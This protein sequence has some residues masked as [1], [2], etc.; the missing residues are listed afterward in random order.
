MH[1]LLFEIAQ[2]SS[3]PELVKGSHDYRDLQRL[4]R[5]HLMRAS[6]P[7]RQLSLHTGRSL[8]GL[9]NSIRHS[10][11]SDKKKP[12][13]HREKYERKKE[14][15]VLGQQAKPQREIPVENR[16]LI[17][18]NVTYLGKRGRS[19]C[20]N[21]HLATCVGCRGFIGPVPL[22]LWIRAV[23]V[24]YQAHDPVNSMVVTEE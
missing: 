9:G 11:L 10:Y 3:V 7:H 13:R 8:N 12:E 1:L 16:S 4:I 22:P 19:L 15:R 14:G 21:W 23:E 6:G 2:I 20:R 17:F 5:M 18:Q 24:I